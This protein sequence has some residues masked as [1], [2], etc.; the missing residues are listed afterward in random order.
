MAD[1]DGLPLNTPTKVREDANVETWATRTANGG[2]VET[3]AK[4]NSDAERAQQL[5]TRLDQA[6][7]TNSTY[8]ALANPS[9]AH[10]TAQLKA[11]TRQVQALLRFRQNLFS[12]LD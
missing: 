10:N 2:T 4:P 3:R 6:I 11:L 12:A 9:V 5:L 1:Y 7:A 8:I